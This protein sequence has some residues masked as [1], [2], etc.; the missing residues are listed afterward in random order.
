MRPVPAAGFLAFIVLIVAIVQL[1]LLLILGLVIVYLFSVQGSTIAIL[2]AIWAVVVG[3][4]D[5]LP[6]SYLNEG[7]APLHRCQRATRA[8][9]Q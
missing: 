2:L 4:S 5:A 9:L 6:D 1:P 3:F 8:P 7:N